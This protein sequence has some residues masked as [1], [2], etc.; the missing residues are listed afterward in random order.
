[1]M[2]TDYIGS[3][4]NIIINI[5]HNTE[6]ITKISVD[7]SSVYNIINSVNDKFSLSLVK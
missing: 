5:V 7:Y 6:Y 3:D 4:E 1:M 2:N